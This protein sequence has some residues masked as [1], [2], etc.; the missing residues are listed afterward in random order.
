M[1]VNNFSYFNSD[2]KCYQP[3]SELNNQSNL[4]NFIKDN[5]EKNTY[6][7]S[8]DTSTENYL[9]E[10]KNKAIEK[11]KS[12]FLVTDLSKNSLG[13]I[14][15]NCLIPKRNGLCNSGKL[16]DL[17]KPFNDLINEL[18]G[19]D[20]RNENAIIKELQIE[21]ITNN[22]SCFYMIKNGK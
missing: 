11:Q 3:K 12:L 1:E 22:N 19:A 21:N 14:N 6:E 18:F 17:L 15:Y 4:N 8:E 16:E 20:F 2:D 9:E 7:I 5:F 10:C 13:K